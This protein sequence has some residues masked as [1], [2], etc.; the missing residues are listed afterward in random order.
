MWWYWIKSRAQKEWLLQQFFDIPLE[1]KQY[2]C[3]QFQ[4]DKPWGLQH[5]NKFDVICLSESYLESS[6]ASGNDNLNIKGYNLYTADHPK[7]VKRGGICAYIRESLSVRFLSNAYLQECLILEIS[8]NNRKG[9][10]V[11][12]YRSP[13]QMPDKF[14]SFFNDF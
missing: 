11:S 5:H 10:V 3:T 7:N 4:K 12:L 2:D 9:F 1:F 14:D 8:I 6:I 13:S